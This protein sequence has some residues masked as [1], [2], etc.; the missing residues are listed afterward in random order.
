MQKINDK[1][2][3]IQ[4]FIRRYILKNNIKIKS[5]IEVLNINIEIM[6]ICLYELYLISI[7][8]PPQKNENKFIYGKL[9]EKSLL[10]TFKKI[11]Y[12]TV[13]LDENHKVGSEYRNDIKI[14]GIDFSIKGKLKNGGDIIII[15][16]KT[17][18][19]HNM[20]IYV[21]LCIIQEE[22]LYFIPYNIFDKETYLKN[23][24]GSISYKFKLINWMNKYH[25]DYIYTFNKL[26]HKQCDNLKEHDEIDIM[27]KLFNETIKT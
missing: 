19:A 5:I 18:N 21:L 23:D 1:C 4:R 3:I 8:Y 12:K 26:S 14:I 22:K 9:I 15:N 17:K 25:K 27:T 7:K 6:S 13:D 2:L 24:I 20:K 11:G 16:K 10:N